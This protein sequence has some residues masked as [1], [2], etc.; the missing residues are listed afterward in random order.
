MSNTSSSFLALV[1][2]LS[3]A[4][5]VWLLPLADDWWWH[6]RDRLMVLVVASAVCAVLALGEAI[7]LKMVRPSGSP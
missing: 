3:L 1:G 6:H 4:R 7:R 2:T 5:L